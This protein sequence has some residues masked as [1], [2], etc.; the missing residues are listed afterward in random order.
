MIH[1]LRHRR[2]R[3]REPDDVELSNAIGYGGGHGRLARA[4][5]GPDAE[6]GAFRRAQRSEPASDGAPSLMGSRPALPPRGLHLFYS[7]FADALT[8]RSAVVCTLG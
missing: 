4:L 3:D 1:G 5:E 8:E 6:I 2:P 7:W